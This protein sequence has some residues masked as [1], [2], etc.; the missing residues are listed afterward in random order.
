[1]TVCFD[2]DGVLC[3]QTEGNYED[4]Q[5]NLP[6]IDLVNRL[7]DR[8]DRRAFGRAEHAK[9]RFLFCRRAL[10]APRPHRF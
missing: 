5:P 1:M 8:G 7:Y 9:D 2:I 6:M 4:A 10:G 3:V